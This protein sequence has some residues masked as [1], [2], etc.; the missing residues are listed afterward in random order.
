M[1]PPSLDLQL[2][3]YSLTHEHNIAVV[4][5]LASEA[6]WMMALSF[7]CWAIGFAK[8]IHFMRLY[9][10]CAV[11][12]I[13]NGNIKRVHKMMQCMVRIFTEIGRFS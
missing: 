4:A 8:F 1:S 13:G 6:G 7:F 5:S 10:V 9:M 11:A 2:N 12:L 3:T